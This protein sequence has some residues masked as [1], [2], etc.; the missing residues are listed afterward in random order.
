MAQGRI[1]GRLLRDDLARDTNLTFNTNTLVVDY[2]NGRVGIG[3][4]SPTDLLTVAG[5]VTAA[6]IQ[7][8]NN[9]IISLNA[10]AHIVL[11]PNGVGNV[12]ISST[13]INNQIFLFVLIFLVILILTNMAHT[14]I[15]PP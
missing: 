8:S 1:S 9:Q 4:V 15:T 3:N 12:D 14:T 13:N 2:T 5:N 11:N 10:N 7:I 6:N